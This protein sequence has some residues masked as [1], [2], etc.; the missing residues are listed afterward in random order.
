M[1]KKETVIESTYQVTAQEISEVVEAL[2]A[3][4][5]LVDS[6]FYNK[7]MESYGYKP[8][9]LQFNKCTMEILTALEILIT[10]DKLEVEIK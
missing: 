9:L 10:K 7:I 1:R 8:L 5:K 4:S 6:Q 3:Y 2:S